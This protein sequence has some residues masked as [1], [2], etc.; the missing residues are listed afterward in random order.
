MKHH[1]AIWLALLIQVLA[2][3]WWNGAYHADIGADPDE[4][5][6]A[7]TSLMVRDYLANAAGQ[8]P[9]R[10][11]QTYYERLPKVALGHYPPAFY[12]VAGVWL[13]PLVSAQSLLVLQAVLIATL[14]ALTAWAGAQFLPRWA[15]IIAAVFLVWCSPME[16]IAILVMSDVM[17]AIACLC[18][19]ISFVSFIER[20]RVAASLA[21]GFAAAIAILTKGSGWMLA[22]V[23]LIAIALTRDWRLL[24][25]PSLWLAPLPVLVLALPWQLFSLHFTKEGMSGLT[26]TQHFVAAIP[27]YAEAAWANVGPIVLIL[28]AISLFAV[29]QTKPT[30]MLASLTALIIACVVLMLS[31]PAGVSSR[32]FVPIVAPVM[33][34]VVLA[35][36]H[37]RWAPL[38]VVA[39]LLWAKHDK[40]YT[41]D[42]H[43]FTNSV[44]HAS[45]SAAHTAWLVCSDSRGEGGIIAAAAFDPELRKQPSFS[46]LRGTKELANTD[47]VSHDYKLKFNDSTTLLAHLREKQISAVFFDDGVSGQYRQAHFDQLMQALS[48]PNSGWTMAQSF[49]TSHGEMQLH[50]PTQR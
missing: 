24:L 14:G 42:S 45:T 15:A 5:A 47:W 31:I 27:F 1:L 35:L 25:K 43:G 30:P 11:A 7:V 20:P 49:P 12:A 41:K 13:L 39:S 8:N 3:Q 4:P 37:R 22:L 46:V 17:L 34:L 21:F 19:A 6:H 50:L 26:P 32:Y 23:P 44:Q 33:L 40:S 28:L 16:K 2:L 36:P 48:S 29:I 9:L 18:A 10:F 38:L